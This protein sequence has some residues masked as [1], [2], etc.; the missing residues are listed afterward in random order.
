MKFYEMSTILFFLLACN[1]NVILSF[2]GRLFGV[3]QS[4]ATMKFV[5]ISNT[6][7]DFDQL[8]DLGRSGIASTASAMRTIDSQ[9]YDALIY[10]YDS[11]GVPHYF[12]L[13]IDT[14]NGEIKVKTNLTI[15]KY[16]GSFF[17][18]ADDEKEIFGIR[19]S[20]KTSA[21]LEVAII[22]PKNGQ[23]K[24]CGLYPFGYYQIVMVFACER[25]LYY[26]LMNWKDLNFFYGVNV[27]TGSLDV[28][29]TLPSDCLIYELFYDS[30][31]DRLISLVTTSAVGNVWYLATIEIVEPSSAVTF[32]RI[33]T[34]SIPMQDKYLWSGV[35]T[36]AM[37]ERQWLTLWSNNDDGDE[38]T[39]I[40]FDIDTG[41]IIEKRMI[42]NS[43]YLNNFV[44]FD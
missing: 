1:I 19:E 37:K 38:N 15:D 11:L 34:S 12:L 13:M 21:S 33:G 36:L 18:I 22:D 39:F 2:K 4:G 30:S 3:D 25:R 28:N 24:T 35:H 6:S 9:N 32:E 7:S 43:N 31:T 8:L 41:D 20:M 10:M 26:N 42:K 29:I 23:L 17:Q 40:A 5:Q 14:H 16:S 44:Y 27:D